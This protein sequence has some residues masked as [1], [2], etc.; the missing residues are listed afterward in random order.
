MKRIFLGFILLLASAG[1]AQQSGV[2]PYPPGGTPP[3]FPPEITPKQQVPPDTKAPPPQRLSNAQV[4]QLIQVK[5]KNEPRLAGASVHV[6]A[7]DKSIHL[8]GAV[9]TD[10]Q[11]ELALRI[12]QSYAGDRKIVDKIRVRRQ[13]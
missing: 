11:H 4:D 8:S 7:N 12:V 5:L 9:D 2:P 10:Q 1:L 6:E 13:T 3:T